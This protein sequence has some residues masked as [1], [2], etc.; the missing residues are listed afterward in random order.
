[1]AISGLDLS[2]VGFFLANFDFFFFFRFGGSLR[3]YVL[4]FETLTAVFIFDA[5]F[6]IRWVKIRFLYWAKVL[7]EKGTITII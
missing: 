7:N 1:M 3:P 2:A 5:L 6:I 4:V